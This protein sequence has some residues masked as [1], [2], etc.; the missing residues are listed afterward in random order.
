MRNLVL[1]ERFPSEETKEQLCMDS[2]QE[3]HNWLTRMLIH[4]HLGYLHF[5]PIHACI[6]ENRFS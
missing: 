3:K 1:E 4:N 2:R 6:I 5:G